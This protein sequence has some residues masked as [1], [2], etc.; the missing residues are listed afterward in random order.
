MQWSKDYREADVL[1]WLGTKMATGSGNARW[2]NDTA[3][4]A[5]FQTSEQYGRKATRHVLVSLER[6]FRHREPGIWPM[7]PSNT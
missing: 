3:F 1:N 5:P 2:P 6:N 4:K 7:P